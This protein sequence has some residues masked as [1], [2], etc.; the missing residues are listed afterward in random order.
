MT[1]ASG[2]PLIALR[3]M[4][5]ARAAGLSCIYAGAVPTPA[6]AFA[7]QVWHMPAL[8][9]TGSHIPADRNGI[10]AYRPEGEISKSDER[11]MLIAEIPPFPGPLSIDNPATDPAVLDL[12]IARYKSFFAADALAGLRIGVYEHSTVARD[13]FHTV[14]RC[15]G[16]SRQLHWA[17]ARFLPVDTEA[18]RPEDRA[19]TRGWANEWGVDAIVS[20]DGDADRPLLADESGEW[21]RGDVMGV[22]CAQVLGA[23]SVVTPINSS[24]VLE[25]I[26]A[27]SN[28]IR[29]R[30]GSPHVIAAMT[31]C[32]SSRL[33]WAMKPME[34]S[35]SEVT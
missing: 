3:C 24:T 12:Y 7:A 32:V 13:L 4:A 22:L 25:A 11:A 1:L 18:I 34:N 9:V 23:A 5:A 10:K 16:G 15:L 33:L 35:C 20:A 29:T 19:L 31:A 17:A 14:L 30:I 26:G 8:M 21:L 6:V 28:I 27:F 2:S